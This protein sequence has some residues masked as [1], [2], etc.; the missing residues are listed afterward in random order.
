MGIA[1]DLGFMSW[2]D[3]WMLPTIPSYYETG[4]FPHKQSIYITFL[5]DRA[6]P[7]DG[8]GVEKG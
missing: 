2:I 6:P 3:G 7:I 8:T 5:Q 4:N 1:T